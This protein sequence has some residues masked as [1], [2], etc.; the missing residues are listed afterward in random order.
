MYTYIFNTTRIDTH[1]F[2]SLART[3]NIKRHKH[4]TANTHKINIQ[5]DKSDY[6]DNMWADK[7]KHMLHAAAIACRKKSSKIGQRP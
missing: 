6:V 3:Q 5:K 4:N 2:R 7:H 1:L